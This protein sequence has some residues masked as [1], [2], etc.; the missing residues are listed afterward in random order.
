M[1]TYSVRLPS[2]VELNELL[3]ISVFCLRALL[4][5]TKRRSQNGY[6]KP[7]KPSRVKTSFIP[8][9]V[10]AFK[11]PTNI[12]QIKIV[13][14]IRIVEALLYIDRDTIYAD[15]S[16]PLELL[17]LYPVKIGLTDPPNHFS[18]SVSLV[19]KVLSIA[20][21]KN[22][23]NYLAPEAAPPFQL[24]QRRILARSFLKVINVNLNLS[25]HLLETKVKHIDKHL[26]FL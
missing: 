11:L 15:Y 16:V 19:K 5:I 12:L 24:S 2:E 8:R 17:Y 25:D 20:R 26:P 3:L 6:C 22:H 18:D 1:S 9:T 23:Y 14:L 13:L 7:P 10:N 21:A 4:S